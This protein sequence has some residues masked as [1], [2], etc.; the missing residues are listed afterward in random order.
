MPDI[1]PEEL[2]ERDADQLSLEEKER[3]DE[4]LRVC[5]V[6]RFEQQV[7]LDISAELAGASTV[8]S[9]LATPR[10]AP[11]VLRRVSER[12]VPPAKPP[13]IPARPRRRMG[14]AK[15]AGV[16]SA[17]LLGASGAAAAGGKV[18]ADGWTGLSAWVG[19]SRPPV[20]TSSQ[21]MPSPQQ[22][23]RVQSPVPS[24]LPPTVEE[25]EAEVTEE[26]EV[27]A[28]T[29]RASQPQSKTGSLA[30][31]ESGSAARGP[32]AVSQPPAPAEPVADASTPPTA[33]E[34]FRGATQARQQGAYERAIAGY[35]RVIAEYPRSAEAR[36]ARVVLARLELDLGLSDKAAERFERSS[37]ER[38]ELSELALVGRARALR[39][40]G[41][42][43]EEVA[44]WRSLLARF[45]QTAHR[46][47]AEAR[48]QA[49]QA[50]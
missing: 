6:C 37:K 1:H 10:L 41:R 22:Q 47:V 48:L 30:T 28:A 4:H 43:Q 25:L 32:D 42:R 5:G 29:P 18:V 34:L 7:K 14:L 9:P 44:V 8:G 49:L 3:L 15:R 50:K 38:G 11:Q 12:P 35:E 40:L 2:L 46:A 17:I 23:A 39:K 27:V 19:G 33:T 24:S 45:P 13:A 20:S 21:Q 26:D 31:A 36:T 16:V